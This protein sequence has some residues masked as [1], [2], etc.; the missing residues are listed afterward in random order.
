MPAVSSFQVCN[1]K[2][3][4][5]KKSQDVIS[6]GVG[7]FDHMLD[8]INSHAQI[9]LSVQVTKNCVSNGE[10]WK[11]DD[12]NRFAQPYELQETLMSQVGQEIGRELGKI[13]RAEIL[14]NGQHCS[15]FCC[16]LDEALVECVLEIDPSDTTNGGLLKLFS[17]PPYGVYPPNKGRA[18]I[19]HMITT[20]NVELFFQCLAETSGLNI[21]LTKLRGDNGHHIV[22]SAFKA[23]SR[24]LRNLIDGTN[25]TTPESW[26]KE[27]LKSMEQLWGINSDSYNQG[28]AL[29]RLSTSE[30]KTKE[31]SISIGLKLD[32][33]EHSCNQIDTGINI[34]NEFYTIFANE[35]HISLNV[36]CSGDLW[37]DDHHT[38]EDIS[39]AIGKCL[40][41][42]LGNKAGLNRMWNSTCHIKDDIKGSSSIVE[43]VMDLSNRPCLTCDL[44][45]HEEEYVGDLSV[46][47]FHHALESLVIN[48]QMTLHIVDKSIPCTD[49]YSKEDITNLVKA[50]AA[51]LGQAL[52]Q[53]IAVDPRRAG[54]IASSKGTLSV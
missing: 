12:V 53:C 18:K 31:T 15:R 16:P 10:K 35:A 40:N 8:Q 42:A 9:G 32:G 38:A 51:A 54:A 26:C 5:L 7:F 6:T 4:D 3:L 34:M 39:I 11:K 28:L 24:A 14:S 23:F 43:A 27:T 22:E 20:P 21:S 46:E 29:N 41:A 45:F 36:S 2:V 50:T 49:A 52:K 19:G 47:M 30:R 25:T 37:V 13:L 17:L 48:G 1:V 33:G 44:D